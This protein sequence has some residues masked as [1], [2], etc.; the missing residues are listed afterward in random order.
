MLVTTHFNR[1]T[2]QKTTRMTFYTNSCINLYRTSCTIN[3]ELLYQC[4]WSYL[5]V[6]TTSSYPDDIQSLAAGM[7]EGYLTADFILMHWKN[8]LATYCSQSQKMCDKLNMFLYKNSI[9]R[10]S[11]IEANN[12]DPYWYQVLVV[13]C[14]VIQSLIITITIIITIITTIIITGMTIIII[15]LP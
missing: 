14:F 2:R 4:R 13:P 9:F 6:H 7:V 10:S 1:K 8:T 12:L 5:E 3:Y 15:P 11:Q